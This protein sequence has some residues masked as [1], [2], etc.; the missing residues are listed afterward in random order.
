MWGAAVHACAPSSRAHCANHGVRGTPRGR[1]NGSQTAA[2]TIHDAL[3]RWF[4]IARR[5]VRREM[6]HGHANAAIARTNLPF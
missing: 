2:G 6:L 5:G 4:H 3:A 1:T